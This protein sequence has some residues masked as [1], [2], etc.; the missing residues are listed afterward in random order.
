[1]YQTFTYAPL[2]RVYYD[3]KIK[4]I[5]PKELD[6][7]DINRLFIVSS[8]TISKKTDEIDKIKDILGKKFVG[9][10]D[11]CEEHSPLENVVECAKKIKSTRPDMILTVGGGTP[12]DT[13]K[14]SQLCLTLGIFSSAE[15]KKISGKIQNVNSN[16]RQIAVPTTLSGGE[17]SIVG[18]AMDTKR[19]LKEGYLG[20]DLCPQVV[21]L[22]P[23][24]STHTPNWLWLSTA[25][26]SI[27]HA[28]E[29]FCSNLKNPLID[30][31]AL[32]TLRILSNSLR[33]TK[34]DCYNIKARSQSQKA[35]WMIAKNMG[36]VTMGA[37][38][39]IGYL[40]GSIGSVP[41]GQTSCV[42]LP[43]VLKWNEDFHPEKDKMIAN[44]L[45][46]PNLKAYE[47]VKELIIDLGLP[48]C[49]QDVGIG[50]D[51]YEKIVKYALENQTVLANPKPIS[52]ADD[53]FEILNNAERG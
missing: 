30:H 52:K 25:I 50:R 14:V 26:R 46:R 28:I 23:Y 13:V 16:I 49:L 51:K 22:D 38:H 20:T 37:S 34:D 48:H 33:E 19:K 36:N 18:G 7:M 8:S 41:H 40:L 32:E 21:I 11:S 1:M 43:A 35:V 15:L 6:L 29:G 17:Y 4:D 5:L 10:F 31:N 24:I 53:I 12:I 27:D 9:I 47:A 3:G 45:G 42:M 44:A 39:G 2:D